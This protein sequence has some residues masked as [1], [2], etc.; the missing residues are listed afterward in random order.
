MLCCAASL[1]ALMLLAQIAEA[2]RATLHYF[3]KMLPCAIRVAAFAGALSL[4]Y[5]QGL[6]LL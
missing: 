1:H 6:L 5:R 2:K 3:D 4:I